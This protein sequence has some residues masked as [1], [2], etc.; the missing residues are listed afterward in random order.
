LNPILKP[1]QNP[2]NPLDVTMS[3]VIYDKGIYK[4]WYN[5]VYNNAV[6]SIWYAESP[7][8]KSW[9]TVGSL[10]VL[11]KGQPGAWDSYSVAISSVFKDGNLFKM[12]YLGSST[13][14]YNETWKMG[15][16]VSEDG[17]TWHKHSSPVLTDQ[18]IY[19]RLGLTGVVKKDQKYYGYF[20]YHNSSYN[21][22]FIGM[23]ESDDGINWTMYSG[24]PILT[25]T[26]TWEGRG[27]TGPSVVFE[28]GKF[29]MYYTNLNQNIIGYAEST[30]GL[31]FIKNSEP[32]FS[33]EQTIARY[34]YVTYISYINVNG[35]KRIY[36][37]G[38]KNYSSHLN[39]FCFIYK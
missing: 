21:N 28:S 33:S 15:L 11:T 16:A 1:V 9:N 4:M 25:A 17:I 29:Q 38:E 19:Y 39:G 35:S 7:D 23:A 37:T 22:L 5:C 27:V 32:V 30:D 10:P 20:G 6:A 36:Y 34:D 14:P 26:Q 31:N 13:H 12:Y 24:N 2:S 18:G 8:G 3:K